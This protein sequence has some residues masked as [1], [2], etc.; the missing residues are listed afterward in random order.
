MNNRDK[1]NQRPFAKQRVTPFSTPLT[2]GKRRTRLRPRPAAASLL[3]PPSTPSSLQSGMV[4]SGL[5]WKVAD[6]CLSSVTSRKEEVTSIVR[7][8]AMA[9]VQAGS[10]QCKHTKLTSM[11]QCYML[12]PCPRSHSVNHLGHHKAR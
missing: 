9:R 5:M 4:H 2:L 10:A 1:T 11:P 12:G 6:A 3:L 8:P 7:E